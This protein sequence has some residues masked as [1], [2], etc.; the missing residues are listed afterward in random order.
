MT[1]MRQKGGGENQNSNLTGTTTKTTMKLAERSY[2]SNLINSQKNEP[3]LL[4]STN[5]ELIS[6]AHAISS[7]FF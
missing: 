2:F 5:D 6:P 3:K 7:D 4:F 1:A